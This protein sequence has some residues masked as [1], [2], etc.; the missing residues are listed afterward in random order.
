MVSST[1]SQTFNSDFYWKL[2]FSFIFILWKVCY[3]FLTKY[4]L[5]TDFKL[6]Y[7]ARQ[8]HIL[9]A[10]TSIRFCGLLILTLRLR[11][12]QLAHCVFF[13]WIYLFFPLLLEILYTDTAEPGLLNCTSLVIEFLCWLSR[14]KYLCVVNVVCV[15]LRMDA[16]VYGV[17]VV[18]A[19]ES[20]HKNTKRDL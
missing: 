11:I 19:R 13:L 1:R 3:F 4:N 7:T 9:W 6:S 15:F 12:L 17:E 5:E 2:C 14:E 18:R 16:A 10:A 8:Q 20:A